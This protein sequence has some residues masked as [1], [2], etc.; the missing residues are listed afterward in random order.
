MDHSYENHIK[1]LN[2]LCRVCGKRTIR[3]EKKAGKKSRESVIKYKKHAKKIMMLFRVNIEKDIRGQ[4]SENL[5][6]KCFKKLKY[7]GV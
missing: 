5:C 1:K 7:T 3:R 6:H 2:Q 4:H